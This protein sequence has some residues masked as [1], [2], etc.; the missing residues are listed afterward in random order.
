[1]STHLKE[2]SLRNLTTGDYGRLKPHQHQPLQDLTKPHIDSFNALIHGGLSR[3]VQTIPPVDFALPNGDRIAFKMLDAT[4]SY[5][6][7][8][9]GNKYAQTLKVYPAE[10]RERGSSY[11]GSLSIS[12]LWKVNGRIQGTVERKIADVPIMVKSSVCNLNGLTPKELVRRGE[13]AEEMGGYFISNGNEKVIRMLVMSR[14]NFPTCINRP[15][16]KNRGKQYTEYGVSLRS[17]GDDNIGVNNVLH[18]LSNGSASLCFSH[19][20]EMFF[21]PVVFILKALHNV[22]DK[23][24]YDQLIQGKEDNSFYKGCV[25]AMLRHALSE[26]LT[27]QKTVLAYMG[28]IFRVKLSLPPWYTDQ[29]VGEYLIKYCICVHLDNNIDKFHLLVYMTRKLFAFA[30]GEC[31]SE[32]ADN[33]MFQELLLGGQLYGMI[34]KEKL[35]DWMISVK[36]S[37]DRTAKNYKEQEYVLT[38]VTMNDALR[39]T[40]NIT[41]SMEYFMASGSI[42]S[43]SGLGLMQVTG[44]TVVADKLNFF[45]YISHFRCVHR[46]S[47]FSEMRTTAVRKLLPEAWGFLCP[48]H[49]PDGS[50]CGLLNHLTA[51]AGAVTSHLSNKHLASLLF[52][53]GTTPCDAPAMA[54]MSKCFTVFLD[55][56]ILGYLHEDIAQSVEKRLRFM[57]VKGLS[58]VPPM[59]EIC[60]VPK[61]KFASQYPGLYIFTSTARMIRPVWNLTTDCKEWIGTFE[62]VYMD[63]C[64]TPEEAIQGVT[65]HQELSEVS[66][67]STVAQ[68]TPFSDFNQSPRNMYQCQMGKQT[69]GFP[70]HALDRRADNKLYKLQTPQSPVVRPVM[71]DHYEMDTYPLGTNAIVA[72]MSYTGY[73]MEDAMILNKSSFERGFAH[74]SIYKSQ[75]IDLNSD[76]HGRILQIFGCLPD[77]SHFLGDRLTKEGLPHIGT[78]LQRGD[79]FYSTINIQTGKSREYSYTSDEPAYVHQIKAL[80]DTTGIQE[81]SRVCIVLRV[82]RNPI[83]GDKFSSRHGQKGVCSMMW[84]VENMPFTESGMTPDILFNPHGYPSRMTI[85]MMIES[86]A[87]KSASLH[88]VCHDATPFQFSEEEPAIDHFGK[89]LVKAGYNYY[90]TERMFSGVNGQE[91]EADIFIGVVYYQRLRHMVSDK[92]QVRTTGP[93][94]PLTHQP[95]K[96]RKRGGGVRFG[97]MERDALIAHGTSYL[98]KDRLLDCSDVSKAR[99]CTSCGSILSPY[100][101]KLRM[102]SV[103]DASERNRRWTCK[104]CKQKDSVQTITL[105]FVFR[106]LVAELSAMNIKVKLDVAPISSQ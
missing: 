89:L 88:G 35:H 97:E 22:T 28:E 76:H 91:L 33:P 2:P 8:D 100:L 30:K 48:V 71:Y 40:T 44:L 20:K 80:G 101:E 1:M 104:A 93:V 15:S 65:T 53:M 98:L 12:M 25:I 81:L 95:V 75:I 54:P 60:L 9:L 13:E 4:I 103:T 11:L 84:P 62:Q 6:T 73:D 52:S 26:N 105:P 56:R 34:L 5:P 99:V 49:T 16:W 14:R 66:M 50:P 102:G 27:T 83:I 39:H 69:M 3:A 79:P 67:L 47:F 92:F 18:Y 45:R 59:S 17:V 68:F 58:K 96:G 85:G 10:C 87:G 7:V 57:K 32:S 55:G 77:N 29:D 21:V 72:V 64:I 43:R 94:D 51:L 37:I 78:Y 86:M 23:F 42:H 41:K 31:A 46:G 106:Y 61:T 38:E 82:K 63:I 74:A 36:S 70:V 24:I 90:G 19:Q